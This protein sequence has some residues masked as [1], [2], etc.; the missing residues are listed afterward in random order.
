VGLKAITHTSALAA[1]VED[2][3]SVSRS[4]IARVPSLLL[5]R[6]QRLS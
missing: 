1:P 5:A 4:Q 6:S 3:N 2:R